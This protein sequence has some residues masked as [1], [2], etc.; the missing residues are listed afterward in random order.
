MQ[1]VELDSAEFEYDGSILVVNL[2]GRKEIDRE[3]AEKHIKAVYS[4]TN[5]EEACVLVDTTNSYNNV[6]SEARKIFAGKHD[7]KIPKIAEAFVI[8]Q[9]HSRILF[10]FY[11]KLAKTNNPCQAF[12]TK[13]KAL[14][15]LNGFVN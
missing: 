2:I 3:E 14:I 11:Q 9:L 7:N 6:T 1:K 5:G 15:W 12:K 8:Q 13:D 10:R 4:I